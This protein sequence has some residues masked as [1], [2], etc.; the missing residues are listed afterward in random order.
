MATL[1]GLDSGSESASGRLGRGRRPGHESDSVTSRLRL[2]RATGTVSDTQ[3]GPAIMA[4]LAM[5]PEPGPARRRVGCLG[6]RGRCKA[7][8]FK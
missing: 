7:C 1:P 6:E 4:S 3:A 5:V 2:A 8:N